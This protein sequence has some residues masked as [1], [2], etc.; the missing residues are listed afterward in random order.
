M[1]RNRSNVIAHGLKGK[2]GNLIFRFWA[3]RS[4]VSVVPDYRNIVW[5]K[6]QK[7]NRRRFHDAMEWAKKILED[8][9]IRAYYRK[10]AKASQTIWNVA[11]ADYMKKLRVEKVDLEKYQGLEGD[12]I[13]VTLFSWYEVSAVMLTIHDAKGN[14]MDKGPAVM[15]K[16]CSKWIYTSAVH[17]L[18]FRKGWIQVKVSN[19]VISITECFPLSSEK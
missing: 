19:H 13:G 14:I 6:A 18:S 15:T 10:K 7:A 8:P 11:V 3:N 17:N 2:I 4:I 9:K 5:S 1:A 16:E 12:M